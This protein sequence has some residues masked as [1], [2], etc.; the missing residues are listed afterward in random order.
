MRPSLWIVLSMMACAKDAPI[1]SAVNFNTATIEFVND[2]DG[3]AVREAAE[4]LN[5]TKWSVIVL[6]L[7]D[8]EGTSADNLVLSQQRADTVAAMLREQTDIDDARI[9]TH[10]IGEK[11]AVGESVRERKVEFVFFE[12]EGKP[13]KDVVVESGV[14]T[15]DFRRKARAENE[16]AAG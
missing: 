8:A 1:V 2:A 9:V 16:D 6:G 10:A 15:P 7:A 11:L 3:A 4:V 13:I 12:D 14:L 5:S